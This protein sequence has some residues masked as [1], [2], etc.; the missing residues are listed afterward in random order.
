MTHP[1]FTIDAEAHARLVANAEREQAIIERLTAKD[2]SLPWVTA[3]VMAGDIR[4]AEDARAMF[5]RGE[6]DARRALTLTGSYARWDFAHTLWSE[7]HLTDDEYFGDLCDLWSGSDPD[8]RDPK[9]LAVW[10]QAKRWNGGAMLRDGKAIPTR[11]KA[12]PFPVYRGQMRDE[13]VGIAWT[14]DPKTAQKF[15][16][17]AG[18]RISNMGGVVIA[19]MAQR[20]DVLAYITGRG[21][22]EVIIDPARITDRRFIG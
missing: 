7:G 22:S 5:D 19:G 2:P 20:S 9:W 10:R 12:H 4:Q 21:E 8:D 17:G 11:D 16:N 6:I 18:L 3:I 15:A 1:D 13:S 14:R